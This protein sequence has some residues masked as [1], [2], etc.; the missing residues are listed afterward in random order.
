MDVT[1]SGEIYVYTAH[2]SSE[3]LNI[4]NASARESGITVKDMGKDLPFGSSDHEPFMTKGIPAFLF[5]SGI[6]ADLH[7]PGDDTDRIDFDKMKRVSE[8][9]FL[10]GYKAA[11][12]R[13]RIVIDNP[14]K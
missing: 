3:L 14:Q 6:H 2:E 10:I 11:N 7:G 4:M 12:Q 1:Q 13:E 8:M 9:V 5:H